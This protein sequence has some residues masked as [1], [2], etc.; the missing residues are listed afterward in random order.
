M[1]S[2]SAAASPLTT[3]EPLPPHIWI[4]AESTPVD[5]LY[6]EQWLMVSARLRPALD[7]T[8]AVSH[9]NSRA[10]RSC[11]D[12]GHAANLVV[13]RGHIAL[14]NAQEIN[15]SHEGQSGSRAWISEGDSQ[16]LPRGSL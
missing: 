9:P 4:L 14:K 10:A 2:F 6:E 3:H 11:Q 7:G 16:A 5:S 15:P 1:L 13:L 12:A 8:G